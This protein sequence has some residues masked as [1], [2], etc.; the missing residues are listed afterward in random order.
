MNR[1][2][3][4][5][6]SFDL[7]GTLINSYQT[8][9]K[10]TLR[11]LKYLNI[12]N[13]FD[14]EQFRMKIGHHFMDVFKE[15]KIP[16]TDFEQFIKIYK[17]FYFDFIKDSEIYPGVFEILEFLKENNIHIS[18]LT[19]K[20]Q[21]QADK[22]I[23]HFNLRKYFSYIMGRREGVKVKPSPEGL[24]FICKVLNVTPAESILVGDTE[25]DINCGKNAA[26][27]TCAVL[28]GYRD[29]NVLKNENPDYIISELSELKSRLLKNNL[30]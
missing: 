28:Y 16:V 13:N 8:I 10:S 21:E 17:K 3:I 27:K 30:L 1:S 18:L 6:I 7:D 9:L 14:E 22:I 15:L 5:H 25:L 2:P 26:A 12:S 11:A 23:D 24:L 19:T 29:Q 4:K 20:N